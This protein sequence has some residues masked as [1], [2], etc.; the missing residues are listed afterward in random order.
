MAAFRGPKHGGVDP[1]TG[2]PVQPIVVRSARGRT[3]GPEETRSSQGKGGP[4]ILQ[5]M[6]AIP[7]KHS[8]KN[9]G[10]P[11]ESRLNRPWRHLQ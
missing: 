4:K 9:E 10:G 1:A 3:I 5:D 8:A 7:A 2:L 6:E 11:R